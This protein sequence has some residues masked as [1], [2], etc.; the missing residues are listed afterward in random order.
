MFCYDKVV[1]ANIFYDVLDLF[2]S[3]VAPMSIVF[4][5]V[6]MSSIRI[7]SGRIFRLH[8]F[9]RLLSCDRLD[10]E[11]TAIV[12]HTLTDGVEILLNAWN[13]RRSSQ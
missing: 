7:I 13:Q 6:A 5:A 10:F 8:L 3:I 1:D 4:V 9:I 2:L 12:A 11:L